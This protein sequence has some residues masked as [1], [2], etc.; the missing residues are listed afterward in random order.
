MRGSELVAE[1]LKSV[2][3][4]RSECSPSEWMSRNITLSEK[5]SP[6]RPGRY[7]PLFTP[8]HKIIFDAFFDPNYD[9]IVIKKSSQAGVT[10]AVL[11]L[12]TYL[13]AERPANLMYVIDSRD[14]VRRIVKIRLIPMLKACLQ[15]A[16]AV[17]ESES[18]GDLGT[19]T[20]E[21]LNMVMYFAGGGSVGQLANKTVKYAFA[22][23]LEKHRS[24]AKE[25]PTLKLLRSRVKTVEGSKI[26][27]FS[28]PSVESGETT[29]EWKSGTR[30]V[31]EV[32][33]PHCG[34]FHELKMINLRFDH[35]RDLAGLWDFERIERDSYF[36]CPHCKGKIL[37][38]CKRAMLDAMRA[39][40][41]NFG[42][43][44]E[45][46]QSRKFSLH[47]SDFYSPFCSWGVLA[48]E[49]VEALGSPLDMKNFINGRLGEVQEE[50]E[51]KLEE[52]QIRALCGDYSFN[53]L[54]RAPYKAGNGMPAI[55]I[56]SDV[57]G[58]VKKWAVGAMCPG[59]NGPDLYVLNYG[60]CFAFADLE[61]ERLESIR[62][63]E[64][65]AN[66]CAS[67]GIIDEGFNTKDVRDFVLSNGL[68]IPA[69]GRGM[70]QIKTI[71]A[72]ST[73][74][75][76][77]QDMRVLH[78][79]DNDFKHDLYVTRIHNHAAEET[80]QALPRVWLPSCIGS[81]YVK[82]LTT[83]RR[84]ETF[85]NGKRVWKWMDPKSGE[86]ND[87]GDA[88]KLILVWWYMYKDAFTAPDLTAA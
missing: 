73:A 34:G 51:R 71:A 7:D 25:V 62:S 75:H 49:F 76:N 64:D 52:E 72:Y 87:W 74:H 54:P 79:S 6:S 18:E 41:T 29:Q 58:D 16:P 15:T 5:E 20:I 43:A 46:F 69:K 47:I 1:V 19:T 26:V 33:C 13:T 85:H 3:R 50:K 37:Q 40:Q 55:I 2:Y 53:V 45:R 36:E 17:N 35:C 8:Y 14:E 9:E 68:W 48:R 10:L 86:H 82:E 11:M 31:I 56:A 88:T 81:D 80:P 63:I 78:F 27:A 32:P 65:D 39:R 61:R 77:N 24:D 22:D 38:S 83:E 12:I 42:K 59:E 30:H 28:S 67:F 4:P 84:I 66:Y 21:L 23:E 70:G 44:N 57:Q 60:Q